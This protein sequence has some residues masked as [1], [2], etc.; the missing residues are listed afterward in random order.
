MTWYDLAAISQESDGAVEMSLGYSTTV[1]HPDTAQALLEDLSDTMHILFK[2]GSSEAGTVSLLRSQ[3]MPRSSLR[4]AALRPVRIS[5]EQSSCASR[6]SD[7]TSTEKPDDS[8]LGALDKIWF[9]VFSS[10][11][12]SLKLCSPDGSTPDMRDL[13][14]YH[15][16]GNLIDVAHLVALVQRRIKNT[17]TVVN[18]KVNGKANTSS[19]VQATIG[20]VLHHPS[21]RGLDRFLY[22]RRVRVA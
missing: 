9:S 21:L 15:L 6:S 13:P 20:D 18:R 14:F 5:K 11:R 2:A 17:E 7:A 12:K 19:H 3:A 8:G 4:L 1:F 22:Q 10:K 16:G